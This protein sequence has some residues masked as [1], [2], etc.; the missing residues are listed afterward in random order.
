MI[1]ASAA[2]GAVAAFVLVMAPW[3]IRQ[4]AVFGTLSPSMASGKVLFIR[5]IGE[6]DSIATPATLDHLL[7]MGAGPLIAS[8]V[9]GFLAAVTIYVVLIAG[10]VLA[11]FIVVGAWARRRSVDFGPFFTYAAVLFGFSALVSAVHVPGGT[12]IHS[13][14]ALAPYSYVLALEGVAVV[15]AWFGRRRPAWDPG[16]TTR[17]ATVAVV[18]VVV[19]GA[20]TSVGVVHAGWAAGRDR[21]LAVR[22]ALDA[23]GAPATA[24]VM[25]I[26]AAATRYWTGRGGVVLV[27]DPVATIGEVADAYDI[28]WL[29][30]DRGAVDTTTPILDGDRPAWLGDADPRGRRPDRARRL[31]GRRG[32]RPNEPPRSDPVRPRDLRRR[33]RRARVLRRADRVPEARGHGLLRRGRPE[34]AQRPRARVRCPVELWHAAARGPARGVRGVAAAA[35]VPRRDPDGHRRPDLRGSPGLV[36]PRRGA[37]PGARMAAGGRR[38]AGA[39][40]AGR[41]GTDA[42]GWSRPD[43]GRLSPAAAPLVAARLDD[44]VHG[45]R[46]ARL[47]AD[48]PDPARRRT[49]PGSSTRGCSR[50]AWSS[51]LRR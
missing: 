13:A 51:A 32:R 5:S 33:A 45:A 12:F 14:V 23:A 24:R 21:L 34:P 37:R 43:D 18:A 38:G 8:R 4:L 29:V 31:P 6:W 2:V 30:L 19:L 22:D 10:L 26:D 41:A 50:L 39:G 36:D 27:N 15:V 49:A 42:G 40:A 47:P 25:S 48:D 28:D 16:P 3:W 7:G 9:G 35:D 11:P 46:A 17:L 44:G 20:L 1:P